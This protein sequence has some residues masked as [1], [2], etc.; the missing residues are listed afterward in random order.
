MLFGHPEEEYLY[1]LEGVCLLTIDD[2]EYTLNPGDCAYIP[3]N[4]RHFW[5]NPTSRMLRIL[6]IAKQMPILPT[7]GKSGLKRRF[8]HVKDS[9]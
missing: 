8:F 6:G 9:L 7:F 5:K 1:I 4:S 2:Q 3:P